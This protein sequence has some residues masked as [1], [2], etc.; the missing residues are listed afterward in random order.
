MSVPE[1]EGG[2]DYDD[3]LGFPGDGFL[4]PEDGDPPMVSSSTRPCPSIAL[5]KFFLTLRVAWPKPHP[6]S[7]PFSAHT[8][9][10]ALAS[11]DTLRPEAAVAA[12]LNASGS[13]DSHRGPYQQA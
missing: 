4:D 7:V 13:E 5:K 6:S 8:F 12:L 10:A 1:E 3:I 9:S 11:A 2:Q